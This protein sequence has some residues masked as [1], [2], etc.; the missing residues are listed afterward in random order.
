VSAGLPLE[1]LRVLEIG[2]IVAGPS[3]GLIL[4][5][6]GADV[7]KVEPPGEGDQSRMMAAG[8]SATFHFLNRNKRSVAM[9]IKRSAEARAVFL[10]PWRSATR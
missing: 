6:L 7:I 3:A 2:H 9:D 8:T 4:A 1:G 5:D 10:L